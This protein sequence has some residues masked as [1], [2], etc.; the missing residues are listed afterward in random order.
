MTGSIGVTIDLLRAGNERTIR[1]PAI[2]E[3]QA[4]GA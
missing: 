2:G 4:G 1:A 3:C